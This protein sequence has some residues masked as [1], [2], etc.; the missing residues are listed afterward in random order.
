MLAR[1]PTGK[2]GFKK[3]KSGNPGGR[4]RETG[5]VRELARQYTKEAIET[6]KQ[7]M[8]SDERGA[9]RVAAA[10]A[11]LD[12]GYGRPM[13]AMEVSGPDQSPIHIA[14]EFIDRPPRESFEEWEAR[15]KKELEKK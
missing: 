5:D 4:K 13:Q 2:G 6:L 11:L 10:Q 14:T 7:V 8:L 12:R 1:N 9:A 3:G 15:R